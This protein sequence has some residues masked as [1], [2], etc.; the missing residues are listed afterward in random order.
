MR[1]G[2]KC[3]GFSVASVL[4]GLVVHPAFAGTYPQTR[5]YLLGDKDGMVY[6]GPG[7]VDDVYVDPALLDW[8][9]WVAPSEPNDD[10]DV[11]N[12]NNNV[13]FTFLFPLAAEEEV[14]G[15]SL[16]VG[17]RAVDALY[18]TDWLVLRADDIITCWVYTFPDLGWN[19][20][21]FTGVAVRTVD[22]SNILGDNRLPILQDGKLNIHITDDTAVDYAVLT[23]EVVPEPATLSLLAVG[24]GVVWMKRRQKA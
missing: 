11:L 12:Y 13:P 7:S 14:V 1:H 21:P 24:L 3:I 19:P 6:G 9:Q 23:I 17:L 10:F 8:L 4:I 20:L 22:L 18:T 16:T 5:E 15:A 2:T